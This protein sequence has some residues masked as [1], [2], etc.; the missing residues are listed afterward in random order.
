MPLYT[1][2][3]GRYLSFIHAYTETFGVAPA[4][5][6]IAEAL[7][8][9]PP[10][11]SGMLKTMVKKALIHKKPGEARS[12]E[13]LIDANAIPPWNQALHCN[14]KFDTPANASK[15]WIAKRGEEIIAARKAER[16]K[17]KNPIATD[18]Q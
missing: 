4:E 8:V 12:I 7:E 2:T 14:L 18:N 10:S 17:A 6:E 16:A 13:I 15:A 9:Q 5:A 3:Q 1:P 11:V